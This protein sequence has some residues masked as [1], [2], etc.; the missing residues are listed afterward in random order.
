MI[1]IIIIIIINDN[2]NN[3]SSSLRSRIRFIPWSIRAF[4]RIPIRYSGVP[5]IAATYRKERENRILLKNKFLALSIEKGELTK[6]S[7]SREKQQVFEIAVNWKNV[8]YGNICIS[9]LIVSDWFCPIKLKMEQ[10]LV[11]QKVAVDTTRR[12]S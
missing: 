4:F 12:V 2:K 3:S 11:T 5:S 9:M 7:V 10:S 1:I 6:Y 8:V